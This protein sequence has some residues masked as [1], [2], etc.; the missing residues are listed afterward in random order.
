MGNEIEALSDNAVA[1][2]FRPLVVTELQ[3]KHITEWLTDFAMP[4]GS[5][6]VYDKKA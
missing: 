5:E 6:H 4:S 3:I 2:G 1:T